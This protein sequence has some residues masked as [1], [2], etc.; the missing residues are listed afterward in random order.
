VKDKLT[1]PTSSNRLGKIQMARFVPITVMHQKINRT[2]ASTI[3][4]AIKTN[5]AIERYQTPIRSLTGQSGNMTPASMTMTIA[6]APR[7]VQRGEPS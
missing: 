1:K 6:A 4:A 5:T 3:I 7:M 2:I